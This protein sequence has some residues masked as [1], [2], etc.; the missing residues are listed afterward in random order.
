[1][2]IGLPGA[3]RPNRSRRTRIQRALK[4]Y[5][6]ERLEE[7]RLLAVASMPDQPLAAMPDAIALESGL[8]DNNA[9]LDLV[10]LGSQGKLA[11]ALNGGDNTWQSVQTLDLQLGPAYGLASGLL[12]A[13]ASLDLVAVGADN[14]R[15]LLGDRTGGFTLG[16]DLAAPSGASWRPTDDGLAGVAIAYLNDDLQADIVLLDTAQQRVFV[17]WGGSDGSF[18]TSTSF[19]SGGSDPISLAVGDVVGDMR[20]DIVVGHRDG[21]I[22]LLEG[23]GDGN[24]TL[25]ATSS[26][27][28]RAGPIRSLAIADLDGDG[29]QDIAVS[30]TTE[31]YVLRRDAHP[32]A[33]PPILNG[34]FTRGLTGWRVE[35]AGEPPRQKP[36]EVNAVSGSVELDEHSS[37]LTSLSQSFAVP[38]APQTISI[39]LKALGLEY[40]DGAIP[41]A[42]ELSLLDSDGN[43]LVATHRAG[44]TSF[45]NAVGTSSGTP[46]IHL[47]TGVAF[48]GYKITLD[49]SGLTAG[50]EATLFVDLIGHPPGDGASATIDN[51]TISP[52]AIFSHSF[53]FEQLPGALALSGG[54]RIGDVDGDAFPDIIVADRGADQIVVFNGGDGGSFTRSVLDAGVFGSQPTG[55]ALSRL[56]GDSVADIAYTLAEPGLIVTPLN[57]AAQATGGR[58]L[59]AIDFETDANGN[60][61]A[62]GS[63]LADQFTAWGMQVSTDAGS[64][65]QPRVVDWRGTDDS[66]SGDASDQGKVVILAL[67]REEHGEDDEEEFEHE[68]EHEHEHEYEHAGEWW[69]LGKIYN[70]SRGS[71]EDRHYED[72]DADD[73]HDDDHDDRDGEEHDDEHDH[74]EH[75]QG[76]DQGDDQ[77]HHQADW[78]A[79]AG[80]LVFS[81]DSPVRLDRIGLLG[82]VEADRASVRA[83]SA[84][85]SLI[86]SLDV[87]GSYRGARQAIELDAL[88]VARLEVDFAGSGAISDI[89]FCRDQCAG[90]HVAIE[91]SAENITEGQTVQLQLSSPQV[92]ASQWLIN[93]GDGSIETLIGDPTSVTHRFDDGPAER[94]I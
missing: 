18:S 94:T 29:L 7:R 43:S 44:A 21:T 79:T 67:P 13:D 89:V 5:F 28:H 83:Y 22:S 3:R 11:V 88:N 46:E 34:D 86:Q 62:E 92:T 66:T 14:A 61:L 47:A 26:Q 57:S 73:D 20:T 12:S 33:G 90:S 32:L 82:I 91:S 50:T 31:A 59:P 68:H 48:D 49:I 1:M 36:G 71:I 65:V 38:P 69:G 70:S 40:A 23:T 25:D 42:F 75:D 41:D 17:W 16:P 74:D 85:G 93:W 55:I 84:G 78:V 51:V 81:F 54:M 60:P 56:D 53:T 58:C 37:F 77:E 87:A 24:F 64:A 52:A 63:V 9:S 19:S 15:I 27:L 8:I 80:T 2:T 35:T 45:F 72:W 10:A 30:A 4:T 6:V 76:D 39:D